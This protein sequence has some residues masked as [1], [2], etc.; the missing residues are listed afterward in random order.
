MTSQGTNSGGRST[1]RAFFFIL[2]AVHQW[3]NGQEGKETGSGRERACIQ[4]R[5]PENWYW[6]PRRYDIGVVQSPSVGKKSRRHFP[7]RLKR[8]SVVDSFNRSQLHHLLRLP[9]RRW[10]LIVT[11]HFVEIYEKTAQP[12]NATFRFDWPSAGGSLLPPNH[13]LGF[14]NIAYT[15]QTENPLQAA[16]PPSS[17][18]LPPVPQC[19]AK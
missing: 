12:E 6:S 8:T 7:S 17:T 13:P 10:S 2:L 11:W 16:A 4:A 18:G 1:K 19:P 9:I 3:A 15:D 5:D 14:M